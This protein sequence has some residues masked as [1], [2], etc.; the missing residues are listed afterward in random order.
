M[1]GVTMRQTSIPSSEGVYE[2]LLVVSYATEIMSG[3]LNWFTWLV[4][5]LYL[6]LAIV[7][8]V[9]MS[10]LFKLTLSFDLPSLRLS[11]NKMVIAKYCASLIICVTAPTHDC[12]E[13]WYYAS[14]N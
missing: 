5:R 1:L 3:L 11:S 8:V 14:L 7:S 13:D 6:N 4:C 12:K 10:Q 2:I 9:K